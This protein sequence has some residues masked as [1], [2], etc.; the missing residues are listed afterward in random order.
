MSIRP[1][2]LAGSSGGARNFPIGP[3]L[4]TPPALLPL[5]HHL[6]HFTFRTFA[7][8]LPVSTFSSSLSSRSFRNHT[9]LS[10]RLSL[11]PSFGRLSFIHIVLCFILHHFHSLT[12]T[13]LAST[14]PLPRLFVLSPA[15]HITNCS[16]PRYPLSSPLFPRTSVAISISFCT[17][18]AAPPPRPSRATPR[19]QAFSRRSGSRP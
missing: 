18:S 15:R 6:H 5:H 12:S 2:I 16:R 17:I 7:S 11:A 10:L 14:V 1:G 9:E 8:F 19:H 4:S 3:A 13:N